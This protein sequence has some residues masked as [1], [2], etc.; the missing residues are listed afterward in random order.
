M[1]RTCVLLYW[2]HACLHFYM[3]LYIHVY[4]NISTSFTNVH[5]CVNDKAKHC[6]VKVQ[7]P[8]RHMHIY[9]MG[10]IEQQRECICMHAT[11]VQPCEWVIV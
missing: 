10:N 7:G 9:D 8:T 4:K 5:T 2:M 3:W 6:I 1:T 11:N